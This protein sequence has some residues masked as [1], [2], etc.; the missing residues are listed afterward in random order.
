VEAAVQHVPL[1]C[2]PFG[3]HSPSM[4]ICVCGSQQ[5]MTPHGCV[6]FRQWHSPLAAIWSFPQQS[7]VVS[8][9][10]HLVPGGQH[11]P[12]ARPRGLQRWFLHGTQTA[13][14]GWQ[15]H[16]WSGL[17]HSSKGRPVVPFGQLHFHGF[18]LVHVSAR[19]RVEAG[20]AVARAARLAGNAPAATVAAI[21]LSARRRGIGSARRLAS[22]SSISLIGPPLSEGRSRGSGARSGRPAGRRRRRPSRPA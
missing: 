22:S 16:S 19:A 2:C 15:R 10:V 21:S 5:L 14:V 17:Q 9:T 8:P 7:E 20:A 11:F 1:M 4:Q 3:Q 13:A 12:P 6:P 18:L